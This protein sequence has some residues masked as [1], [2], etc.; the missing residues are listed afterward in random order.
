MVVVLCA[1]AVQIQV[2]PVGR[3]FEAFVRRRNRNVSASFQELEDEEEESEEDEDEDLQLEEHPLLRSL[4]PKDWK[5]CL[6]VHP[7]VC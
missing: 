6:L 1:A 2:E 5:V 7:S 4:D 3:W